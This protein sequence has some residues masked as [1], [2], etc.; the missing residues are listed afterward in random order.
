MENEISI[1]VV[2]AG[3]DEQIVVALDV[4]PGTTAAEALALSGLP[5]RFTEID[6]GSARL[7][8]YGRPIDAS[9]VLAAGDR[10]EIYR[11]LTADPKQARR[12]RARGS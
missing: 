2:Y 1:E 9:A 4:T 6:P 12:R 7:G 3:P 11:A 10:L 8:I 5:A